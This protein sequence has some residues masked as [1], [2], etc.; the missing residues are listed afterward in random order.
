MCSMIFRHAAS[1]LFFNQCGR[2]P[3]LSQSPVLPVFGRRGPL[4]PIEIKSNYGRSPIK[5]Q[6]FIISVK[7]V[8]IAEFPLRED[9]AI[10][11]CV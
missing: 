10:D 5:W 4:G 11:M 8:N 9:Y 6:I 7:V 2:V 3:C 1:R